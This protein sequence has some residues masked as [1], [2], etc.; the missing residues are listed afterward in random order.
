MN[1]AEKVGWWTWLSFSR[2]IWESRNLPPIGGAYT[3]YNHFIRYTVSMNPHRTWNMDSI[4]NGLRRASSFPG[5]SWNR[6]LKF[7]KVPS[8]LGAKKGF[9]RIYDGSHI[10]VFSR[11]IAVG[12]WIAKIAGRSGVRVTHKIT[13]RIILLRYSSTKYQ[14]RLSEWGRRCSTYTSLLRI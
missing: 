12:L 7:G 13:S 1:S 3:A 6:N 2:K 8:T 14:K 11:K 4:Y 5:G 10:V 9:Q